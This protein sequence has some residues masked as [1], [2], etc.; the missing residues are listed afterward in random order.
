M[1]EV[2]KISMSCDPMYL[3]KLL[4]QMY[5]EQF[6]QGKFY[7]AKQFAC[8]EYLS[9]LSDDEIEE[10]LFEFIEREKLEFI[11][12]DD[13][14]Y[15]MKVIWDIVS[16]KERYKAIETE[17]KKQGYGTTGFGVVDK[18]DNTFYD[19][20]FAEHWKAVMEIV[21]EKYPEYNDALTTM[22]FHSDVDEYKGVTRLELDNFILDRFELIGNQK[23]LDDYLNA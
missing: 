16:E 20:K 23:R 5:V 6:V 7:K 4:M 9:D 11:T 17:F 12:Y 8:Y 21:K 14:K 19:C 2:K 3:T 15:D 22:Y 10:I 18:S 13:W 1:G